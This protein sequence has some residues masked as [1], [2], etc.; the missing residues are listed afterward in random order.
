MEG[1]GKVSWKRWCLSWRQFESN[2]ADRKEVL[3]QG[4]GLVTTSASAKC[5]QEFRWEEQGS[6]GLG[7]LSEV[8]G[9]GG[10]FWCQELSV[11]AGT[12][13]AVI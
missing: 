12:C 10:L 3:G 4:H 13:R 8:L 7:S 6:A 1:R 5:T 2:I 9:A 11:Q